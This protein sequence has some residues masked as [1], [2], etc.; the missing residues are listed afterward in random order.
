MKCV[1]GFETPYGW[2]FKAHVQMVHRSDRYAAWV[3][4]DP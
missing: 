2:Q 1:C 4:L 3:V